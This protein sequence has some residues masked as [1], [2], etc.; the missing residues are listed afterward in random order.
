MSRKVLPHSIPKLFPVFTCDEA[1]PFKQKNE[2]ER[3]TFKIWFA[4]K[5]IVILE[6]DGNDEDIDFVSYF[7]IL[8]LKIVTF[9]SKHNV[10]M[11]RSAGKQPYDNVCI[12]GHGVERFTVFKH[13]TLT[14]SQKDCAKLFLTQWQFDKNLRQYPLFLT[15][16]YLNV[17]RNLIMKYRFLAKLSIFKCVLSWQ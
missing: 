6:D 3:L 13:I 4:H 15:H 7:P 2:T 16:A 8:S 1:I 17:V 14:V 5:E 11:L 9:I 10:H 12:W